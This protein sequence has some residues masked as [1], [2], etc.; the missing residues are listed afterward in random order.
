M[1]NL[2]GQ[3]S[4]KLRALSVPVVLRVKLY[5]I[6]G[7]QLTAATDLFDNRQK[8][9]RRYP[10][11]RRGGYGRHFARRQNVEVNSQ[12]DPIGLRQHLFQRR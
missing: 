12:V 7:L 3:T 5:Q 9:Q 10:S 11:R 6:G 1:S 8:I 4:G 2:P